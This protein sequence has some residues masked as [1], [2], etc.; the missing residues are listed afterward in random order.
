MDVVL[1]FESLG[2]S[3]TLS[4]D[5]KI[6]PKHNSA[7]SAES[8]R[9]VAEMRTY[10]PEVL[11]YLFIRDAVQSLH[12]NGYASFWSKVLLDMVYIVKDWDV[13]ASLP[14][15]AMVFSLAEL[16]TLV[17]GVFTPADLHDIAHEKKAILAEHKA[18]LKDSQAKTLLPTNESKLATAED[19]VNIFDGIIIERGGTAGASCVPAQKNDQKNDPEGK[20]SVRKRT[21]P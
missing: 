13:L 5:G 16:R 10:K 11:K 1:E 17:T 12:S 9:L 8:K 3:V 14:N 15:G 6:C 2:H 20:C 18:N 4:P 7:P 19:A 21:F